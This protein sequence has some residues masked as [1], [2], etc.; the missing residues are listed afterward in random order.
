MTNPTIKFGEIAL[1][2]TDP[3]NVQPVSADVYTE[4]RE[5]NGIVCLSFGAIIIDGDAQPRIVVNSRIRLTLP[6]ALDLRNALTRLL[7]GST[8]SKE[9]AN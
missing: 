6:A 2:V 5:M 9:R 4:G 7:E 1:E 8:P 3:T